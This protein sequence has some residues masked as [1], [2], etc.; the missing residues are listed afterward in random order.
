MS[1]RQRGR[2][3]P[4]G[5]V[6]RHG[7]PDGFPDGFLSAERASGPPFGST[8]NAPAGRPPGQQPFHIRGLRLENKMF[9]TPPRQ[10]TISSSVY[11][12]KVIRVRRRFAGRSSYTT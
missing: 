11:E 2:G 7:K 3:P 10:K 1:I 9:S 12:K 4:I 6:R 5:V 8:G